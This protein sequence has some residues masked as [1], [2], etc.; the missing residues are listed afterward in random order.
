MHVLPSYIHA[1]EQPLLLRELEEGYLNAL[2]AF[3]HQRAVVSYRSR[4]IV[5]V[6][7][8]WYKPIFKLVSLSG[9]GALLNR[10]GLLKNLLHKIGLL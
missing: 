2:R 8:C 3:G 7:A 10:T 6:A 9:I 4:V 5:N 1:V